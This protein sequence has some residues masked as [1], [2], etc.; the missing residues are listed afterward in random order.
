MLIS[1]AYGTLFPIDIPELLNKTYLGD[2]GRKYLDDLN[3][4]SLLGTFRSHVDQDRMEYLTRSI[5]TN[6]LIVS[7]DL[8]QESVKMPDGANRLAITWSLVVR[9]RQGKGLSVDRLQTKYGEFNNF[10]RRYDQ[11]SFY[12]F[13]FLFPDY[14]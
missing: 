3:A 1:C 13:F 9:P 5:E 8:G 10:L 4:K 12:A 11:R 2:K 7:G 6:F 14:G